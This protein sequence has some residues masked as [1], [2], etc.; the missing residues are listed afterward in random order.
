M[1]PNV[2]V[3][4]IYYHKGTALLHVWRSA[5]LMVVYIELK[6]SGTNNAASLH[7]ETYRQILILPLDS[8]GGCIGCTQVVMNNIAC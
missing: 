2:S 1:V 6:A 5:L 7:Y 3:N 4:N 8:L